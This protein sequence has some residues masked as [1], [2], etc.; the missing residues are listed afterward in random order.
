[1]T[2]RALCENLLA[3]VGVPIPVFDHRTDFLSAVYSRCLMTIAKVLSVP[4]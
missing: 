4:G 1:M 2:R 3:V